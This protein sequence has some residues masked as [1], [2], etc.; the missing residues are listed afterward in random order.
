MFRITGLQA[1]CGLLLWIVPVSMTWA[2]EIGC[3]LATIP[4]DQIKRG[5]GCGYHLKTEDGLRTFLQS[6]VNGEDP[7]FFVDG[8]LLSLEPAPENA[9]NDYAAQGDRFTEVF[10]RDQVRLQFNNTVTSTCRLGEPGCNA[11]NF[12]SDLS[13]EVGAC[14]VEVSGV[15]GDCGC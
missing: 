5:C 3:G 6:G 13:I 4:P 15:V 10:S 9:S 8:E 12:S 7:R 11:I 2:E 1:L 14:S